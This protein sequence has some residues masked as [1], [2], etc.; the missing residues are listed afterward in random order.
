QYAKKTDPLVMEFLTVDGPQDAVDL[1]Q[2]MEQEGSEDLP[3]A[4]NLVSSMKGGCSAGIRVANITPSG[5]VYPCQFAQMPEFH[6]GSIRE[7][8][9]SEIWNDPE[10]PILRQFRNKSKQL[11]GK[12]GGCSYLDLCGGGCRVRAFR[13]TG[14]FTAEDPFCFIRTG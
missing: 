2:W 12:C 8:Q 10:N 14:D 9:F 4:R 6:I 5:D 1:L 13:Q 11:T 7:K 3:E